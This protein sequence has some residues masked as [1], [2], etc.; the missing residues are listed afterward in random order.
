MREITGNVSR[1]ISSKGVHHVFI[2][3]DEHGV[4]STVSYKGVTP[5]SPRSDVLYRL[6]GRWVEHDLFRNVFQVEDPSY[7]ELEPEISSVDTSV[8]RKWLQS[9][10]AQHFA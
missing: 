8:S 4:E 5:P 6:F 7:D 10:R 9:I 3:T 1:Y 2:V